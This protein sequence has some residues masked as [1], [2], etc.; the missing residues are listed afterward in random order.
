[1]QL[2]QMKRREFIAL[3]GC[4]NRLFESIGPERIGVH[5]MLAFA[6]EAASTIKA[7]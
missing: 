3:I 2:D 5:R 6:G 7:L 4:A 1:M